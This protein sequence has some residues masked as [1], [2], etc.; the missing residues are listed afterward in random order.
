MKIIEYKGRHNITVEFTGHGNTVSSSYENFKRGVIKNIYDKSVYNIGFIGEGKYKPTINQKHTAR[1]SVWLD[2]L[3]RCFSDKFK[4]K[5]PTYKNCTVCDEWLNFQNFA[6][7]YEDNFYEV[8]NQIMNIDKDILFK[9]NKL[10]CPNT[11]I[12]VP[13]EINLLFIKYDKCRGNFPIGVTF[14]KKHNKFYSSCEYKD[15]N[16]YLGFYDTPEEAFEAYKNYKEN[17]IKE[18]ADKYKNI[19]PDKLYNAMYKYQVEIT[20]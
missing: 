3:R 6:E 20:D 2:M 16:K 17:L 15:N 18:V 9:K 5:Y 1:Y 7:W 11:C 14:N 12:F 4:N 13:Q 8:G 10:Y 19:I